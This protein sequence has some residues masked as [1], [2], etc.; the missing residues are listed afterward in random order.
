MP[1]IEE[2]QQKA[3]AALARLEEIANKAGH[4]SWDLDEE[5][6]ILRSCIYDAERLAR[7]EWR[8]NDLVQYYRDEGGRASIHEL[9]AIF[10][11]SFKVHDE[12]LLQRPPTI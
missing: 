12:S 2:K 7:I 10:N 11:A 8:L 9:E 6:Q 5:L 4:E 1:S 3:L